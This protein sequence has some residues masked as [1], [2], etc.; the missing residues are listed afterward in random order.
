MVSSRKQNPVMTRTYLEHEPAL[1]RFISRLIIRP[2]DVEDI[3]QEVFL[4]AFKA[5]KTT[6]I[7]NPKAFLFKIA[8]NIALNELTRKSNQLT[9]FIEDNSHFEI[10]SQ[11]CSPEEKF[12][13]RQKFETFCQALETL[14]PQCRKVFIM[15]KVYGFSHKEISKA[16]GISTSTVEKH[17]A[18]GLKRSMDIMQAETLYPDNAE[19]YHFPQRK[20]ADR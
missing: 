17:I 10:R 20:G 8:K 6:D 5:E 19:P 16:L 1:K 9:D 14:P 13:S 4:R 11:D 3:S 12:G 2:Q 18:T 15:R 7:H